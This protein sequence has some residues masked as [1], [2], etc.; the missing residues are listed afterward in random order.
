[1]LFV[2]QMKGVRYFTPNVKT[3]PEFAAALK[4]AND[5]GV[6]ISAVDCLVSED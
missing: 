5:L 2:V 1:M 3:H 6:R 4:K